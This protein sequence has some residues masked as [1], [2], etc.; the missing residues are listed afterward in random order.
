M[1]PAKI[2]HADILHLARVLDLKNGVLHDLDRTIVLAMEHIL[3]DRVNT[4]IH[5][6]V[7]EA[8]QNVV[9]TERHFQVLRKEVISREE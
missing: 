3:V 8:G 9:A 5:D 2:L 6:Q 4:D 1:D 7:I